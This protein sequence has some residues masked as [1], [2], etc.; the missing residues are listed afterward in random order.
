MH[1]SA[2]FCLLVVVVGVGTVANA[3]SSSSW[4]KRLDR[5]TLDVD[6]SL[7]QR[8]RNLQRVAQD[9]A[10]K[11]DVKAALSALREKGFAKGHGDAIELLWP[12]G[13][14]A[15]SDLEG[16]QALRK[17]VPEVLRSPPTRPKATG[18]VGADDVQAAAKQIAA[19]ISGLRDGKARRALEDEIKNAL[20]S[21]PKGLETPKYEVE[22]AFGDVEVRLYEP[23]TVIEAPGQ[24]G[25]AFNTLASFLF[26]KNS[27]E[28]RMEMTMPVEMTDGKMA[29]VLPR[30]DEVAPPTPL[31][32]Q[33]V[34]SK[35]AARRVVAL[36]FPGIATPEEIERQ[37][38][39]L[40]AAVAKQAL[41][42]DL[43]ETTVLQYNAPYTIP[44][45]RR[46][47][48]LCVVRGPEAK[49]APKPAPSTEP[50]EPRRAPPESTSSYL[51]SLSR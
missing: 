31:D 24:Q 3:L 27:E 15:R 20:R 42:V 46:N 32:D 33:V 9:P 23:F 16:L 19:S 6:V 12:K 48:I 39:A 5:A 13:T 11:G 29:F 45:R 36:P 38:E 2:V 14:I 41:D 8:V 17:Q 26:G 30:S 43:A 1:S 10:V 21:T 7:E 4:Q 34:I 37:R 51:D 18:S 44:W 28:K 50:A 47:E 22:R 25:D 35:R 49:P 40:A